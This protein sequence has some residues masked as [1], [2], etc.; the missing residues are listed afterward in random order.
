MQEDIFTNRKLSYSEL[1]LIFQ[2]ILSMKH[3]QILYS[4]YVQ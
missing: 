3:T 4:I 1:A 2:T